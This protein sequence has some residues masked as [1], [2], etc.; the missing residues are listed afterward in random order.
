M[1]TTL[2]LDVPLATLSGRSR[3]TCPDLDGEGDTDRPRQPPVARRNSTPYSVEQ[4]P[5]DR[6][7]D[8]AW[9]EE[10]YITQRLGSHTIARMTGRSPGTVIYHLRRLGIPI[11]DRHEAA[12]RTPSQVA[13]P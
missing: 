5:S 9:L 10:K 3:E 7:R 1:H 8:R 11:R 2:S 13:Y 12:R 6:L 4:Y